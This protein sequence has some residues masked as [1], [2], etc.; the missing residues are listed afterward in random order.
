MSN[1]VK[2][3]VREL[4]TPTTLIPV[5]LMAFF[6]GA[7][8][9]MVGGMAEEAKEKPTVGLI[10]ED[11]S[12]LSRIVTGIL[13][14]QAKVVYFSTEGADVQVGLH[15]LKEGDGVALLMVPSD[16]SES[17]YENLPGEIR[18]YWVMKGAGA[19]DLV[20]TQSIDV[21]IQIANQEISKNLVEE[22]SPIDPKVVINPIAKSETTLGWGF[23]CSSYLF[24]TR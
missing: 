13:N 4:L 23:S 14:D 20:P 11:N 3:E 10:D 24:P 12:H 19:M 9:H 5:I 15:V 1:I 16:F 8:G 17:I 6:F 2:K 7:F 21:L 18:V 22:N